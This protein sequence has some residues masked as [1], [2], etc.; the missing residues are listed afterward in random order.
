MDKK[1]KNRITS[2][3]RNLS[4]AYPPRNKVKK[5][6][7]VGPATF[8]CEH[9]NVWIYEGTRDLD[10]QRKKLEKE[11]PV[12]LINDKVNLDHKEPVVP[13]EGFER[14]NWDWHVYIER[15]FCDSEGFQVLCSS[16]HDKKT[17]EEDQKRV[18]YRK[19]T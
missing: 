1:W 6:Q 18:K 13:V 15:M 16:C 7:Q 9:C 12:D 17:K 3:L 8:E 4:F 11:P 5:R 19:K 14:G 10:I 2:K